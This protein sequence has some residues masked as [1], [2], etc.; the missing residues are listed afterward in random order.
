MLNYYKYIFEI[1]FYPLLIQCGVA[2]PLKLTKIG[3]FRIA[4]RSNPV[5]N[6]EVYLVSLGNI[7][8]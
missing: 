6:S 4:F 1:S 3:A 5:Y 2:F 8:I 7:I